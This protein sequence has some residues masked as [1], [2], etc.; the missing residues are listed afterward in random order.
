MFRSHARHLL[1]C[2]RAS[3]KMNGRVIKD[4][5]LCERILFSVFYIRFY[6]T[7]VFCFFFMN[8]TD[9]NNIHF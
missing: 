9:E 5:C 3:L 4:V 8:R 2:H 7:F 6:F 1:L